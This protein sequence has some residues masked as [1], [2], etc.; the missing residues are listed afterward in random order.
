LAWFRQVIAQ[1]LREHWINVA[2]LARVTRADAEVAETG[3]MMGWFARRIIEGRVEDEAGE[4]LSGQRE[5]M[6][7]PPG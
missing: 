3:S 5:R 2:P 6:S 1:T 7:R 4:V